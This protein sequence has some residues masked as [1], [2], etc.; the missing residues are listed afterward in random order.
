MKYSLA[1]LASVYI[2]NLRIYSHQTMHINYTTY[3]VRRDSVLI[4][5]GT[6][7][8]DVM[9][10]AES[11]LMDSGEAHPFWYARVLGIYHAAVS[12]LSIPG[13]KTMR[14]DILFVRWLGMDTEWKGG[15]DTRR[16]DRV[17]FVTGCDAF[18]FL[19]PAA[20]LRG[21]HLIPNFVEGRT[22]RLLPQHSPLARGED[23]TD[24][25]DW[26]TF[27]VN[28]YASHNLTLHA[29]T[30]TMLQ[31]GF[32]TATCSCGTLGEGLGT[33][34]GQEHQCRKCLL[35]MKH[36]IVVIKCYLRHSN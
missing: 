14:M 26:N 22:N 25:L 15:W 30:Y 32:V 21:C 23:A 4:H 16:L 24:D 7:R 9:L 18:G 19:D 3:D 28:R 17:G 27:Y 1:Q 29:D 13:N 2:K 11:S 35:M 10:R 8:A 34:P 5:V 36:S 20:I 33:F 12:D 31:K 6:D